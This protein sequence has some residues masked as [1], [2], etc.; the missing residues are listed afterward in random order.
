MQSTGVSQGFMGNICPKSDGS[1]I[2]Y[3]ISFDDIQSIFKTYPTVKLKYVQNVPSKMS[4]K[5]FWTK[6]FQSYYVRRDKINSATNDLF[7][8]CSTKDNDD[9]KRKEE[10]LLGDP[11]T[12]VRNFNYYM[13]I[14]G[15]I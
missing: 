8:D 14:N 15:F 11:I 13:I 10:K 1:N 6:F 4:E 5:D 12:I 2:V 7:A 3:N 9:L